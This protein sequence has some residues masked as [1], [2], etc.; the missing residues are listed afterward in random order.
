MNRPPYLILFDVDAT[1]LVTGGAGLRAMAAAG[2]RLFGDRFTLGD[3][4]AAGMLDHAIWDELVA[5]NELSVAHDHHQRF[6]AAYLQELEAAL[7]RAD[8]ATRLLPGVA[9]LLATLRRRAQER[10]DVVLG[11]LTGN[12][13]AAIPIKFAAASLDV[14]WF[15][16]TAFSEDG[17]TRPDL[18]AAAM[19]K[20]E[21]LTGQRADPA[22]VIIVGD[23]PRDID[24]AGAH[25][26]RA[27][28][29]ATGRYSEAD[30]RAAGADLV[31]PDLA[32]PSPLLALLDD[33]VAG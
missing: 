12:Y 11:L 18:V 21:Q 9:P 28:A 30:L 29:V 14:S 13:A 26:C 20:Y 7:A 6:H 27:V 32:D 8:G 2:A 3:L 16:V 10:G 4:N 25:A 23:T 31:L 19:R 22:R 5:I 17:P 15:D 33:A 24:C 1:L